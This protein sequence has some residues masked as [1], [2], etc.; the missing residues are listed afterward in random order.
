MRVCLPTLV[1]LLTGTVAQRF[2]APRV[3]EMETELE[4]VEAEE[5]EIATEIS[6][7]RSRLDRLETLLQRS[8]QAE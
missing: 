8:R 6:E 7:I 2:I 3:S 1:A 4:S 5:G